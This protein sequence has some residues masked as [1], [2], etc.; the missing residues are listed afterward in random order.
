MDN[1]K[2]ISYKHQFIAK[3]AETYYRYMLRF[4]YYQRSKIVKNITDVFLPFIASTAFASWA[5]WQNHNN[6][7]I[8]IISISYILQVIKPIL[9]IVYREETYRKFIGAMKPLLAEMETDLLE[10][11]TTLP[12]ENDLIWSNRTRAY[13]K[14]CE[15]IESMSSGIDP[16]NFSN[17]ITDLAINETKIFFDNRFEIDVYHFIGFGGQKNKVSKKAKGQLNS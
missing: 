3:Y 10:L 2:K 14:T 9:P 15:L 8:A 11:L 12:T 16:H 17:R 1:P 5:Y 7:Y 13:A 6:V 4:L